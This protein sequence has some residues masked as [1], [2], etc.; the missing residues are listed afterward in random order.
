M[1]VQDRIDKSELIDGERRSNLCMS[2]VQSHDGTSSVP[3][4]RLDDVGQRVT[5]LGASKT[6]IGVDTAPIVRAVSDPG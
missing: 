2:S 4:S 1:V 5:G 6:V 3:G